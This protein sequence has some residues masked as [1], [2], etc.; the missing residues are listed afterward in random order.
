MA[1]AE[2]PPPVALEPGTG[3]APAGNLGFVLEPETTWRHATSDFDVR[4]ATN[5]LGLRGPEVVLPKPPGRYR[6]LALGDSFTFGWGV[7]LEDAWHSRAARELEAPDERS[8]EVVAAGVPGWSPLQQF[9]FLEQRGLDLQPD[10]V[11]WQLCSNDLLEMGRLGVGLDARRLPVSVTAELPLATGVREDWLALFERLPEGD[12][13]RVLA[14]YRAGRID[15]VLRELTRTADAE[16]RRQAGATP[17]GP[18]TG[19]SSEDVLRGLRSGPEFGLRYLEH[20]VSAA[21]AICAG[22]RTPLRVMLAHTRPKP[23]DAGGP[24]DGVAALAA[25]AARQSPR[26]LD[27]A[28][29]LADGPLDALFFSRD[30]HW[31]PAAQPLVARAIAR[32]LAEDPALGLSLAPAR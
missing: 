32:W 8:V 20:L 28:A 14:E 27:T 9:V 6:V 22:R 18:I 10:L 21:R 25:W 30:P 1:R 2:P 16:R 31:T 12:R 19:L 7:E 13:E 24:D 5:S 4:V 3:F 26:V 15:P 29:V 23:K 11:L 17:E